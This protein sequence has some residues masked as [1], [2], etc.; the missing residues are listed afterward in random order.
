MALIKANLD[1]TGWGA[2][3]FGLDASE[4]PDGVRVIGDVNGT[5]HW[6]FSGPT[7]E[8]RVWVPAGYEID[9]HASGGPAGRRSS[10]IH[11]GSGS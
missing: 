10:G 1:T 6:L 11:S 7:V 9:A 5:L 8:M 4:T 2:W 3:A